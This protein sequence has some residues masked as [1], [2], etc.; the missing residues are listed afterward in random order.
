M[1]SL[2]KTDGTVQIINLYQLF[3]LLWSE[4]KKV[5]YV[6][7]SFAL[8]S[9]VYSLSLPNQY[10]ATIHLAP[11]QNDS[12]RLSSALGSM[13]GLPL[14]AL[15]R[16][17]VGE[18]TES[19]IAQEVMKSRFFIENF[20]VD[21]NLAVEVYAANGWEKST[22]SLKLNSKVYD[23]KS[24]KWII[25]HPKTG[26]FVSPTR[27]QLYRAFLG[28][29]AI[30]EAKSTGL[31]SVSIQYYSPKLAKKWLDMYVEAI[32]KYMQTK[33]VAKVSNN[34]AYLQAEIAKTSIAEMQEVLY[35]IIEEQTK[36]KMLAQA[37]PD[38]AFIPLSPS[39]IPE[40]KSSPKRA[41]ICILMTIVGGML[42]IIYVLA[43][44][45]L[46]DN[47]FIKSLRDHKF[48]KNK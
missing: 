41:L 25:K 13:G 40:L 2:D 44:H 17:G 15:V 31:V 12:T 37:S 46:R 45:Y 6:T 42:S 47:T 11:A 10:T 43:S 5:F 35:T 18:V 38:Y 34:I 23:V 20:I 32:N 4:K 22:D 33:Q 14:P 28:K 48:F 7:L 30:N 24:Q 8:F 29:V 1:A 19:Q 21:N 26:K 3:S 16:I 36:A 39:M 27:Y 9:V